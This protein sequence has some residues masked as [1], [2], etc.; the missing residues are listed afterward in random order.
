MLVSFLLGLKG[1][2]ETVER[3]MRLRK[4]L[5]KDGHTDCQRAP[6]CVC[7][8][9]RAS[10]SARVACVCMSFSLYNEFAGG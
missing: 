4:G 1:T 3:E 10:R 7:A 6:L 8:C 2:R 9:V 5:D